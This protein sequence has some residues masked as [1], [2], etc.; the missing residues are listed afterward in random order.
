MADVQLIDSHSLGSRPNT[1]LPGVQTGSGIPARPGL[2]GRNRLNH[3]DVVE[4]PDT[5]KMHSHYH[6]HDLAFK[7]RIRHFTW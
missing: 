4:S 5:K 1:Q 7:E 3:E 6:I 2:R